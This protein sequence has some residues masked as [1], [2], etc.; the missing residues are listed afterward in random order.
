MCFA[1]HESI[2]IY[3]LM[4]IYIF[5]LKKIYCN[6][7]FLLEISLYFSRFKLFIYLLITK[8]YGICSWF[9][10]M[11]RIQYVS[12]IGWSWIIRI[13]EIFMIV[14]RDL[15]MENGLRRINEG[16]KL[17]ERRRVICRIYVINIS[18]YQ[19]FVKAQSRRRTC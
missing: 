8:C 19:R 15:G 17:I 2:V 9:V 13:I 6:V 10:W 3:G 1:V 12:N 7:G 16:W 18:E 14:F 4:L 11:R 5:H